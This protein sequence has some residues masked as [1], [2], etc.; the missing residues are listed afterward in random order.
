MLLKLLIGNF[1]SA[2][3]PA[4]CFVSQAREAAF[5]T[6]NGKPH[7]DD[8]HLQQ[9]EAIRVKIRVGQA[10]IAIVTYQAHLAI[11]SQHMTAPVCQHRCISS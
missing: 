1:L 11:M 6:A 8:M 10:G 9:L 3:G 5:S 7:E 4:S 2:L